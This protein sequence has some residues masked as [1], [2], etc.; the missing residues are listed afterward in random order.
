MQ[1]LT[2]KQLQHRFKGAKRIKFLAFAAKATN[3][4]FFLTYQ[5]TAFPALERTGAIKFNNY[6]YNHTII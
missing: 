6:D 5:G 2:E 1:Q 3:N 4:G